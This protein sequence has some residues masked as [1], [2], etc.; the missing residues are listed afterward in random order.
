[1]TAHK[2]LPLPGEPPKRSLTPPERRRALEEQ[3]DPDAKT[4]REPVD[5]LTYQQLLGA[6]DAL[7]RRRRLALLEIASAIPDLSDEELGWVVEMA[8]KRTP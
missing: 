7:P 8:T 3:V 4:P 5:L 2:P 1:M 6:F